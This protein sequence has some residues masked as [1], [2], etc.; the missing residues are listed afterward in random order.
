LSHPAPADQLSGVIGDDRRSPVI[1]G[2]SSS[3]PARCPSLERLAPCKRFGACRLRRHRGSSRWR[4]PSPHAVLAQGDDPHGG[5]E[6]AKRISRTVPAYLARSA[7]DGERGAPPPL[8]SNDNQPGR[9][10]VAIAPCAR[11][12]PADSRCPPLSRCSP[13]GRVAGR[14][15]NRSHIGGR[16]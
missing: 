2:P 9:G 8:P 7:F 15:C 5:S 3:C 12:T 11:S 14:A 4:S 13:R 10:S 16:R 6:I 1:A